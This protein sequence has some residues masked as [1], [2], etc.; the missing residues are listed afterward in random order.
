M[1]FSL[2]LE[3]DELE[4]TEEE[5]DNDDVMDEVDE[6]DNDFRDVVV[7]IGL[8]FSN[9]LPEEEEDVIVF[10]FDVA[11]FFVICWCVIFPFGKFFSGL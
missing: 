3:K 1:D 8:S 2:F 7:V 4:P 6:V 10:F 5:D 11:T 9:S